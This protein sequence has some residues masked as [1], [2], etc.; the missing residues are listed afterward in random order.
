MSIASLFEETKRL[1]QIHESESILCTYPSDPALLKYT[2]FESNN[3]LFDFS[4]VLTYFNNLDALII[5]IPEHYIYRFNLFITNMQ[6]LATEQNKKCP[7]KH[8]YTKLGLFTLQQIHSSTGKTW[9]INQHHSTLKI[10]HN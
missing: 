6:P 7:N 8:P 1:K 5:H 3:F 2:K 9:E 4:Q 10:L